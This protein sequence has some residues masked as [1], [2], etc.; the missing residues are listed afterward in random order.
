MTDKGSAPGRV[1]RQHARQREISEAVMAAGSMRTQDIAEQF[2]IS[3]MTV[4]R[5]L[6]EL[7]SK[8]LLRKS[9]G[10]ATATSTALVESS[11]SYRANRQA[12][13]KS[14][15]AQAAASFLEPGQAIMIDDSTTTLPLTHH[16][17]ACTPLTVISNS[18]AVV[19]ELRGMR[20]IDVIGLGGNYHAWCS[21]FIGPMT[22]T[23]IETLRADTFFMSTSAIVDDI[24]FHQVPETVEVKQ[25]M[26]AAAR[27]RILLVD[28][29]KFERRALHSIVPLADFDAIV[30]DAATPAEDVHRLRDQGMT[31]R[32]AHRRPGPRS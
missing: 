19:Q 4:H 5:D 8:G 28:H 27:Q 16:M 6:D 15:I 32:V 7:E 26:F 10:S 24:C 9:R 21:A 25:A 17:A 30:V 12:D 23:A 18:L 2:G 31:V 29:T 13:E 11:D 22:V 3:L 20:G 14:M 1:A